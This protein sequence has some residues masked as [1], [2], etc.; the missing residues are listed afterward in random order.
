MYSLPAV[1]LFDIL[2]YEVEGSIAASSAANIC[3]L[4]NC[5]V[6]K[7]K[8][9]WAMRKLLHFAFLI[10]TK[11]KIIQSKVSKKLFLDDGQHP[12]I[13]TFNT[14]LQHCTLAK[15]QLEWG[16]P[17]YSALHSRDAALC[18]TTLRSGVT[19]RGS[20][21]SWPASSPCPTSPST[22]AVGRT[23]WWPPWP[24]SPPAGSTAARSPSSS[25]SSPSLPPGTSRWLVSTSRGGFS[26]Y[27]LCHR[28]LGSFAHQIVI[29]DY[30]FVT[31]RWAAWWQV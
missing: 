5:S 2:E 12:F 1:E 17:V 27:K 25:P 4:Q 16:I 26:A 15:I 22:T 21:T 23:A 6:Q 10:F 14:F 9:M 11:L 19:C 31:S 29:S 8:S 28:T 24:A 20:E 13:C 3:L 7:T 18:R 30:F